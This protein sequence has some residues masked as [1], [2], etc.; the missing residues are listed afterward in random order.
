MAGLLVLGA[1]GLLGRAVVAEARRAGESSVT[2]LRR[3]G[4]GPQGNDRWRHLDLSSASVSTVADLL[5]AVSPSAII[6]CAGRTVGD[7]AS[8][9]RANIIT[10]GVLLEAIGNWGGRPRLVH[11]GSAA[12]YAPSAEG[13]DT[14]EDSPLGPQTAYGVTKA[15]ASGL[16]HLADNDREVDAV[17]ARVFNPLGRG[18]PESS[19]PGRA[20]RLLVR[21]AGNQVDTVTMG[22]LDSYRDFLDTRDIGAALL[23]LARAGHLEHRTFNIA[24]G[25]ARKA[26]DVVHEIA[27]AA[28]FR[29][30]VVEIDAPSPRSGSVAWQRAD[31]SRLTAMGWRPNEDLRSSITYLV[32]SVTSGQVPRDRR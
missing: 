22:P 26:R 8:L 29:G 18:M 17:V 2:S 10:I 6:N 14:A 16:V 12:E 20:A 21:A 19:M 9:V 4:A 23:L 11:V 31:V 1:S 25:V 15:A 13:T 3:G 30:T 24:S 28:G 27:E 32:D 5:A 7:R